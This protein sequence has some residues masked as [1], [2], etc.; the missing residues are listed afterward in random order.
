MGGTVDMIPAFITI[1]ICELDVNTLW[2]EQLQ[3]AEIS[4][5]IGLVIWEW[6]SVITA[7]L[8]VYFVDHYH[9]YILLIIYKIIFILV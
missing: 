4:T 7:T 8:Y 2:S 5:A 3:L 6:C 9:P 1:L